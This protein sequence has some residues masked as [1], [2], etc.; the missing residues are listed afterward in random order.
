MPGF[1]SCSDVIPDICTVLEI[2]A[3]VQH[4]R[5]G[6]R[7]FPWWLAQC[8]S[9]Y[10]LGAQKCFK[11]CIKH[12]VSNQSKA[13]I[14]RLVQLHIRCCEQVLASQYRKEIK[15][16]KM[17]PKESN[18]HEN[19]CQLR[20]EWKK[21]AHLIFFWSAGTRDICPMAEI[22]ESHNKEATNAWVGSVLVII[23][24]QKY[25]FYFPHRL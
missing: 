18:K 22:M 16:I 5:K 2:E 10:A 3:G 21:G 13:V 15:N 6:I 25:L 14:L 24:N 19:A 23:N 20:K 9:K 1:I 17:C 8:E 12:T 11:Y 4:Y 7:G